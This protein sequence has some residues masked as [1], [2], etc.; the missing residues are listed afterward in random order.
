MIFFLK[1]WSNFPST[2]TSFTVFPQ[3]DTA[4]MF[5]DDGVACRLMLNVSFSAHMG[6]ACSTK[7]FS[8]IEPCFIG[9][10]SVRRL[11]Q[12]I[13]LLLPNSTLNVFTSF[14]LI[15]LLS[16]LVSMMPFLQGSSTNLQN[17]SRA[18]IF[19]LKINDTQV[20]FI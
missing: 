2:L 14:L 20:T 8:A 12:W 16:V 15:C 19:I 7:C 4:I 5:H 11:M 3:H 10:L 18:A 6:F 9:R 17:I 1:I 13:M